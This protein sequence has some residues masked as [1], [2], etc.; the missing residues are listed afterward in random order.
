M[1]CFRYFQNPTQNIDLPNRFTFPFYYEPHALVKLAAKEL[2]HYLETKSEWAP[3]FGWEEGENCTG[4]GKM[5]GILVVQNQKKE[6]G[7]LAA[8]SGKLANSNNHQGFVPPVFDMLKQGSF[9]LVGEEELNQLNRKI[10]YLEN[11]PRFLRA[12]EAYNNL[13]ASK[14]QAIKTYKKRLKE[15]RTKRRNKREELELMLNPKPYSFFVKALDRQ[16]ILLEAGLKQL[17]KNYQTQLLEAEKGMQYFLDQI[18]Q[19]K[20]E[21]RLKSA[22]LQQQLFQSYKFLNNEQEYESLQRIF[23]G[24]IP[25][26]GAGEC[27]APKLLQYAFLN[28]LEPIALGEFWWGVSPKSEV[29]RHKQFYPACHSKCKPILSH[30]LKGLHVDPDP[31]LTTDLSQ[32]T[33]K[34]IYEDEYLLAV[35]KPPGLLAVPGKEIRDSVYW[36]MR[37]RFPEL[38][39]VTVVHRLDRSTSGIMLLAKTLD[40]YKALQR[41]FIKKAGQKKICSS[42][43]RSY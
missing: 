35:H 2:Q 31:L 19:L 34:I 29:R 8:F 6:L 40:I 15:E 43:G 14:E 37:K 28:E 41:Q 7:Y 21:R 30:M 42:F 1:N 24:F 16:R 10:E 22:N 38:P 3:Y 36:R 9:Y 5:F 13:L 12:K 26:S 17:K 25:P 4:I 33:I 18:D 32:K 39:E 11:Q 20:T 23:E 27:A